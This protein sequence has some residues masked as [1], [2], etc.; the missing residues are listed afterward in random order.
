MFTSVSFHENKSGKLGVTILY[1]NDGFSATNYTL[2]GLLAE[3][4]DVQENEID[5][6]E[7]MKSVRYDVRRLLAKS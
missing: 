5:G 2:L 6:P 1:E 7:W 4:Y 3:A